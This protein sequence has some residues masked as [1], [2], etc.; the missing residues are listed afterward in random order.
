MFPQESA[1]VIA[2]RLHLTLNVRLLYDPIIGA[3]CI[4]WREIEN[5]A[6]SVVQFAH[7]CIL[8]WLRRV[9]II[10]KKKEGGRACN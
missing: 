6:A 8:D 3:T 9:H 5:D 4:L 1:E 7:R 2:V 10:K